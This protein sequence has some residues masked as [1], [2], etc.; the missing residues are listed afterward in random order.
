MISNSHS[1]STKPSVKHGWAVTKIKIPLPAGIAKDKDL[2]AEACRVVKS[3]LFDHGKVWVSQSGSDVK[4][5]M[6]SVVSEE[7][8]LNTARRTVDLLKL[9]VEELGLEPEE[10]LSICER[11][12][13]RPKEPKGYFEHGLYVRLSE[14]ETNYTFALTAIDLLHLP[15]DQINT[16]QYGE[17][18]Q[19]LCQVAELLSRKGHVKAAQSL[20]ERLP[21]ASYLRAFEM[22]R[23]EKLGK[24][25]EWDLGLK[26][27]HAIGFLSRLGLDNVRL[28]VAYVPQLLEGKEL[29]LKESEKTALCNALLNA[30]RTADQAS[31][32][33]P[34]DP[35]AGLSVFFEAM[36]EAAKK[37]K[38]D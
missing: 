12:C 11:V 29:G 7:A 22:L 26:G 24:G 21:D 27:K 38:E 15:P 18:H 35:A 32:Y 14:P 5:K 25:T 36:R 19:T 17:Y 16:Y 6:P 4:L 37:Q 34:T 20:L 1:T 23:S 33:L 8:P 28:L 30:R 31:R 2:C 13:V 10:A 9:L 3:G